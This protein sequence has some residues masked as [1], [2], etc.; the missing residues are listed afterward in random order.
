MPWTSSSLLSPTPFKCSCRRA[1]VR[2]FI[3][4]NPFSR[5]ILRI[6]ELDGSGEGGGLGRSEEEEDEE[7]DDSGAP[8]ASASFPIYRSQDIHSALLEA[9]AADEAE[10]AAKEAGLRVPAED[11]SSSASSFGRDGEAEPDPNAPI[12]QLS[13]IPKEGG[14]E[15]EVVACRDGG[16]LQRPGGA[17]RQ[18]GVQRRPRHPTRHTLQHPRQRRPRHTPA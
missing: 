14:T 16:D 9:V 2:T 6:G 18:R 1:N 4:S 3:D 15:G 5:S 8:N 11:A 10:E 13:G 17:Q 12:R 7:G